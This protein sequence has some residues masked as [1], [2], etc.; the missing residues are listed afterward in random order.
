MKPIKIRRKMFGPNQYVTYCPKCFKKGV[1]T[2]AEKIKC[3]PF[4]GSAQNGVW[5]FVCKRK[6]E[7]GMPDGCGWMI[8]L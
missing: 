2:K 1:R 8:N 7:N 3:Y 5:R 4:G 6:D